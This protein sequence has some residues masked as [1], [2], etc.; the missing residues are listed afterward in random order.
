MVQQIKQLHLRREK[1]IKKEKKTNALNITKSSKG[2]VKK[3]SSIGLT[4]D[5]TNVSAFNKYF[6]LTPKEIIYEEADEDDT[7]SERE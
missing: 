2:S 1:E 3:D 4:Y 6:V 5:I 7:V